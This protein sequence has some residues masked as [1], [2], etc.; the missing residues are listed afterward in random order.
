MPKTG[1]SQNQATQRATKRNFALY[2]TMG[3]A[4]QMATIAYEARET[5][6]EGAEA[7]IDTAMVAKNALDALTEAIINWTPNK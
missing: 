5:G 1:K 6:G 4:S 2:R 7:V 3:A